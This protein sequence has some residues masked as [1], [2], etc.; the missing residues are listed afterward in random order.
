MLEP[1]IEQ[2]TRHSDYELFLLK[3]NYDNHDKR[4]SR[5]NETPHLPATTNPVGKPAEPESTPFSVFF[6]TAWERTTSQG[7]LPR[8]VASTALIQRLNH[9]ETMIKAYE[10]YQPSYNCRAPHP[11]P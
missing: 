8:D 6:S 9:K 3:R 2:G 4:P 10:R 1:R 7:G 11:G 5:H